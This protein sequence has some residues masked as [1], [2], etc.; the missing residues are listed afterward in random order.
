MG[1]FDLSAGYNEIEWDTCDF[2]G[3][4]IGSGIYFYKVVAIREEPGQ[5]LTTS[6][7]DK[8]LVIR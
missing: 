2:I 3:D 1:P 4:K 8:F 6:K 7:L 5:R